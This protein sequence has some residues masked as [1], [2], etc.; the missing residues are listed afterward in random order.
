MTLITI[1][2]QGKTKKSHKA[3][4]SFDGEGEYQASITDPFSEKEESELEWYFEKHLRFPFVDRVRAK[5]AAGSLPTY[6]EA[7]FQNVFADPEAFARYKEAA[8]AGLETLRFEI[9]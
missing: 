9:A 3:A 5:T 7:L 6:G 1:R 8:K 2:E 4:V